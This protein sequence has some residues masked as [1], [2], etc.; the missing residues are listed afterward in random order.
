MLPGARHGAR[1]WDECQDEEEAALDLTGSTATVPEACGL[2]SHRL[3]G[4]RVWS[5]TFK[6]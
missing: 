4:H 2:C 5:E 3:T 1:E 6:V